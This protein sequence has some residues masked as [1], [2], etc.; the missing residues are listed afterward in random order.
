MI[1]DALYEFLKTKPQINELFDTL[2]KIGNIYLIGG[3]LREYRDHQMIKSLRDIDVTIDV[4]NYGMWIDFIQKYAM[5][6]NRFDGFKTV[7]DDIEVDVWRIE[8]TWAYKNNKVKMKP[9]KV[10]QLP[11]TVFLNVDGIVFDW[12]RNLWFDE[13]YQAAMKTRVLDVV[14][15]DNPQIKLNLLRAMILRNR[16]GMTY[17]RR[18]KEVFKKQLIVSE[19]S[20]EIELLKEQ[21]KR[22]RK[23]VLSEEDIKRELI[24]IYGQ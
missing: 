19:N 4:I 11:K 16:Y 8:N 13:E 21:L 7:V 3:I 12:S 20:L 18:L 22:Y 24:T 1:K 9:D 23:M 15:E 17:S 6:N 5:K 2:S 14:L 10:K